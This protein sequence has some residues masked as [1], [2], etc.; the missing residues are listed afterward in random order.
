MT[1][2]SEELE[3]ASAYQPSVSHD[4][5]L[6]L[7]HLATLSPV[8]YELAAKE[9]AKKLGVSR[10]AIDKKMKQQVA[11]T[12]KG[13]DMFPHE[14]AWPEP[15]EMAALLSELSATFKRYAILPTHAD[16]ALALWCSFTWFI[17]AVK[18]AP[19]LAICSPEKQCGKTTVLSLVNKLSARALPS[20]NITPAAMFR[21]VEKWQPTMIIDEADTFIRDSDEL[22]GVINSGHTRTT[23]FV[24]RTVGD[25]H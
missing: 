6:I 16:T 19:I 17:D 23:A 3:N 8:D 20:A 15:V 7:T 22:R 9:A 25:T 18:V 2:I 10:A 1:T 11:Q 13:N 21:A 12:T 4:K 5:A 24:I 14:E